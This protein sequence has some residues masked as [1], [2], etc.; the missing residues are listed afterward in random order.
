MLNYFH[1]LDDNNWFM[2]ILETVVPLV[3]I[4]LSLL[5]FST[6]WPVFQNC[7]WN[8]TPVQGA[9]EGPFATILV[10]KPLAAATTTSLAGIWI[11]ILDEHHEYDYGHQI[12]PLKHFIII[13]INTEVV[14]SCP[15]TQKERQNSTRTCNTIVFGEL[16]LWEACLDYYNIY[17]NVSQCTAQSYQTTQPPHDPEGMLLLLSFTLN[18]RLSYLTLCSILANTGASKQITQIVVS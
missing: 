16:A 1:K 7:M 2:N 6:F 14:S 15:I 5:I 18:W 11:H 3:D 9:F 10:K 13:S 8:G 17:Y 4:V 12:H